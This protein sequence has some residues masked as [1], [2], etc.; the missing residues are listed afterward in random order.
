MLQF[1][2]QTRISWEDLNNHPIFS[3][4]ASKILNLDFSS[5][6]KDNPLKKSFETVI[7][8]LS[9]E[10][11]QLVSKQNFGRINPQEDLESGPME[12]DDMQYN[13]ILHSIERR[14]KWERQIAQIDAYIHFQRNKTY[15]AHT[16]LVNF[17]HFLGEKKFI[18]NDLKC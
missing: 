3:I 14:E 7:K 4:K 11:F 2:E 5:S 6:S 16:V 8:R 10:N 17:Y 13:S 18:T 1:N 12:S 9:D 15:F